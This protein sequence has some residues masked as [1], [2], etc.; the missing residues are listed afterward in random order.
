MAG[1]ELDTVERVGHRLHHSSDDN[2]RL[3]QRPGARNAEVGDLGILVHVAADAMPNEGAD[4]REAGLLD[5]L[6]YG[7]ADVTDPVANAGL[8]DPDRQ[9]LA[10]DVHQTLGLRRNL[11][12]AD[13]EPGIGPEAAMDQAGVEA[14]QVPLPELAVGRNAMDH[15]VVDRRTDGVLVPL[16]ANEPGNAVTR[17]DEAVGFAVEVEQGHAGPGHRLQ[18]REGLTEDGARLPHQVDLGRRFVNDHRE[19]APLRSAL[20]R[21]VMSARTSS[22][23]IWPSVFSSLW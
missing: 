8:L 1:L 18:V 9:R 22:T 20:S 10:G 13:G 21:R 6:L 4:D 15:L 23:D 11:A 16:V 5:V 2:P 3:E 14:E 12:D 17:P 19:P 7:G